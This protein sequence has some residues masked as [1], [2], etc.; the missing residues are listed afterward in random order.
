LITIPI[1]EKEKDLVKD[2]V[3][4]KEKEPG[5]EWEGLNGNMDC[6]VAR[7]IVEIVSTFKSICSRILYVKI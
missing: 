5:K 7:Q 2:G 4:V 6:L 1:W 3:K